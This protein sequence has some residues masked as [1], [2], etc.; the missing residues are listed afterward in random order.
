MTFVALMTYSAAYPWC[1]AR[2]LLISG[3]QMQHTALC[4]RSSYKKCTETLGDE[5]IALTVLCDLIRK[6]YLVS[7]LLLHDKCPT[8]GWI[9]YALCI[10]HCALC[11]MHLSIDTFTKQDRNHSRRRA[12]GEGGCGP[13]AVKAV[14]PDGFQPLS[15][16]VCLE[17]EQESFRCLSGLR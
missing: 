7:L 5:I 10:M 4:N 3:R 17:V 12:K 8:R 9:N 15:A 1:E 11:I 6:L 13:R 16:F 2:P 14:I